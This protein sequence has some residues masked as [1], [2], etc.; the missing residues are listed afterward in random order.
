MAELGTRS[1]V[2]FERLGAASAERNLG[3]V[4]SGYLA[5]GEPHLFLEKAPQIYAMYYE[6]GRRTYERTGY[7]RRAHD[8]R[9]AGRECE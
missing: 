2:V 1:T 3:S 7:E 4:H 6:T 9:R 5:P 8:V